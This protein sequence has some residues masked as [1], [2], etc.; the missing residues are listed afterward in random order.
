MGI[1]TI[2]IIVEHWMSIAVAIAT[3]GIG[4]AWLSQH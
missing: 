2:S 1:S 4:V 3:V